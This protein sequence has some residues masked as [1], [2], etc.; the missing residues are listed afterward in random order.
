M[1]HWGIEDG[2]IRNGE[3]AACGSDSNPGPGLGYDW[4]G[5]VPIN[6]PACLRLIREFGGPP[7]YDRA[8]VEACLAKQEERPPTQPPAPRRRGLG[9]SLSWWRH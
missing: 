8:K 1:V 3:Y 5:Q 7:A 6:C 2:L 4:L 9:I